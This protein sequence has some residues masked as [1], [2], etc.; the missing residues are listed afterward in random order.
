MQYGSSLLHY[1]KPNRSYRFYWFADY[2]WSCITVSQQASDSALRDI[3][4]RPAIFGRVIGLTRQTLY[5]SDEI[6]ECNVNT[7]CADCGRWSG[8]VTSTTG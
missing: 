4:A 2:A 3:L 1:W 5:P 6:E 8:Y 7:D